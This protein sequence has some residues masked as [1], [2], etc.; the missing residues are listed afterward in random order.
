MTNPNN[1]QQPKRRL[2]RDDPQVT[3]QLAHLAESLD[4]FAH[5][6][7]RQFQALVRVHQWNDVVASQSP[8][9]NTI[10]QA[11]EDLMVKQLLHGHTRTHS[12][13]ERS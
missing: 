9:A 1:S 10:D 3:E 6:L 12:E 7:E 2:L 8:V 5:S 4:V 11:V 13:R